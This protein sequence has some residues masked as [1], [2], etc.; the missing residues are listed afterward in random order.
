MGRVVLIG[1]A[2]LACGLLFVKLRYGRGV[3]YPD[4]STAPLIAVEKVRTVVELEYPP[5]NIT[6]SRDG[7]IFFNTHPFTQSHRFTDA[8]LFELVNGV[9]RP[10]PDAA[11]QKD[12]QFAFGMN[13]DAQNRLWLTAPATL[14]RGRTR[15]LAYD[16]ATNQKV[17]DHE[18]PWGAA[19]FGQDLRVTPD[20]QNVILADAGASGFTGA[21]IVI[22][23]VKQWTVRT[24]LAEDPSTQPQD[25]V[26]RTRQ[27][28]YRIG[29]GL[30]TMAV[31]VD[32]IAL[33]PDGTWLYYATMSHDT[34]YRVRLV[35][36]LNTALSEPELSK[37]LEKVGKKPMS[38]GITVMPDASVLI[39]DVE[40][41][42]IARLDAAGKLQTLVRLPGVVWSDG[43]YVAT[44]GEVLFTDS[45]IPSYIDQLM[46][47]PSPEKLR[48][49]RPYRIY[50]FRLPEAPVA[51]PPA[52]ASP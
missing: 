29:Y 21:A 7:R 34:L 32:G 51:N 36:L 10:Y 5:G 18:L 45:S 13:V 31:G 22:V 25:W 16:L 12:V 14:E 40:N 26:M 24:V 48:A 4:V 47:P 2:V 17:I 33:S 46:R 15:L 49:G 50:G 27:G 19:R 30:V 28:P 39:T 35:D 11:S 20:G 44:N 41:G 6:C 1:A 38:D 3:P 52:S 37:R 9:P 43:V 8:F 23:D 42:A